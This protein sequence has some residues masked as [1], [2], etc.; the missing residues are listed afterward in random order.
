MAGEAFAEDGF[1]GDDVWRAAC[2]ERYASSM[3]F[4]STHEV[5]G[6]LEAAVREHSAGRL[7][8]AL[9]M[10][11]PL[12]RQ[13]P[14]DP[15]LL[16]LTGITLAA[17][18]RQQEGVALLQRS[19]EIRPQRP[20][21]LLNL[22]RA[23]HD[24]GRDQ[25]ALE[26]CDRALTLDSSSAAGYRTRGTALLALNRAQD[27]LASLGEA[28]RLAPQ[29]AGAYAD[30]G[31]A[32]QSAGR[33]R[34]ALTC[35][36][37]AVK[38]DPNL[39]SAHA[40]VAV[41][42]ARLGEYAVALQSW[43]RAVALQPHQAA[44]HNNRGNALK[45]LGRLQDALQSYTLALGIEPGNPDTLHNRAAV[46][47]LLGDYSAALRDFD[48]VLTRRPEN[49]ADLV[50]R[51][52]ALI[53]LGRYDEAL[54]PLERAIELM[55]REPQAHAQRGIALQRL[56]RTADALASFD[57]ALTLQPDLP[58]VLNNRGIALYEL[59]QPEQA[60]GSFSRALVV[61]GAPADTYT[62]LGIV[63]TTLGRHEQA[64]TSFSRTLASKPGDSKASLL[65]GFVQLALGRFREGWPLYEARLK[66][67]TL[68]T[69]PPDYGVP[70]WDGK[71]ALQGRTLLVQAEQGFGDAIH[72]CRY[73][74]PLAAQGI[75]VVFVVPPPL[76]AL[77]R[78]LAA[79]VRV[80]GWDEPIP[81]VD[82]H[83]PLLSLPLTLG[84]DES[85]IPAAVP[86]LA[87]DAE[88]V[89]RWSERLQGLPGLRVGVAWQGNL[90]AEQFILARGRSMP[91]QALAPLAQLSGVSLVSL[92][93]GPGAE[94]LRTIAFRDQVTDLSTEL[95]TGSDAFV[96][97]AAIIRNLD[98]VISTDTAVAHLAGALAQTTW[99][100]LPAVPEWRWLLGRTDCP[101]YPTARL[102]R[103][104]RRG[105]WSSVIAALADALR[106]RVKSGR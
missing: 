53:G 99:I 58:Q 20:S 2:L 73:L 45:Q 27:A 61:G 37:Q 17:L 78:T 86:Y 103:Q 98:L 63:L 5:G 68:G 6:Q 105:D 36:E 23:L 59:D 43:D 72:F 26:C 34:D 55:P 31:V 87:A 88:R 57:R 19:L 102:F 18:G 104:L 28:I 9:S 12:L 47:T 82:F 76:K 48:D 91:L 100:A 35:L 11:Q 56:N 54:V 95:D 44:F 62:N 81:P 33:T 79:P 89:A 13:T 80:R 16:H 41:L 49:G 14:D 69:P 10:Y 64:V 51:G 40:N 32:L 24:L 92:Q 84:T 8:K 85:N 60:L 7:S 97:T 70:R 66:D 67:P 1:W 83:C 93:K 74:P 75:N 39:T 38:L 46:S 52:T 90:A 106:E 101:W 3:N 50:G 4:R 42:R 71:G 94:D 77:L 96:D 25:E 15:D 30:L 21:V 29:D 22:A 65:L